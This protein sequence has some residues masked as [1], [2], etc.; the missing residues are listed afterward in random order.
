M[1][2]S[3]VDDDWEAEHVPGGDKGRYP[4]ISGQEHSHIPGHHMEG[5]ILRLRPSLHCGRGLL[6]VSSYFSMY[7]RG[8]WFGSHVSTD[9]VP[10][11]A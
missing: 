8:Y 1:C 11:W 9:L 3:I 10:T 6:T 4:F 5:L 7:P 2:T